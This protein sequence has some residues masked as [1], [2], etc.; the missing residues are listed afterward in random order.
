MTADEAVA[1]T[2]AKKV[3]GGRPEGLR[4]RGGSGS[5]RYGGG[6]DLGRLL[7]AVPA[8]GPV[9][10]PSD[11]SS[12]DVGGFEPWVFVQVYASFAG[13]GIAL[14]IAFAVTPVAVAAG[15]LR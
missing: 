1:R 5:A 13:Q 2:A 11:A 9:L 4:G 6:L 14:A 12:E 8:Y 7:P 3:R 10:P 15:P